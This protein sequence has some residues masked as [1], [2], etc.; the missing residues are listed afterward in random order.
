MHAL[1]RD[2]FMLAGPPSLVSVHP[3]TTIRLGPF[4]VPPRLREPSWLH[5]ANIWSLGLLLPKR[6]RFCA[7][8][9]I[10]LYYIIPGAGPICWMG[11]ASSCWLTWGA[12]I[13]VPSPHAP[14]SRLLVPQPDLGAAGVRPALRC[15]QLLLLPF[16]FFFLVF[17]DPSCGAQG[18][19]RDRAAKGRWS[20]L[21]SMD[22]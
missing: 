9:S 11:K 7:I 2:V 14:I 18:R 22:M 6:H 3:N 20:K 17:P 4:R 5:S 12:E 13:A 19:A 8:F 1:S 10:L 21:R 16:F 15:L